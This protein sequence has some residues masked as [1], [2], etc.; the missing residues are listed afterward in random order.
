MYSEEEIKIVVNHMAKL[1]VIHTENYGLSKEQL[2][3]AINKVI[4]E[5]KDEAKLFEDAKRLLF[6]CSWYK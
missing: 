2:F 3:E 1:L 5:R 6:S 4:K